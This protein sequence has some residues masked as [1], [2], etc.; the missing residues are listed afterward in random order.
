MPRVLPAC[1]AAAQFACFLKAFFFGLFYL[2]FKRGHNPSG[3]RP[4][5][6]GVNYSYSQNELLSPVRRCQRSSKPCSGSTPN[7]FP[8]G[9]TALQV[10]YQR[11][12]RS[13]CRA[14]VRCFC[15]RSTPL[16]DE[17]GTLFGAA[18]FLEGTA[19]RSSCLILG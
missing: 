4:S 13:R 6:T 2:N 8:A 14:Y 9:D 18:A 7:L 19:H 10:I 17:A 11:N 3:L 5:T 15:D 12:P 1:T 16:P